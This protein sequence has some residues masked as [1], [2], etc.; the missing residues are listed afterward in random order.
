MISRDKHGC[1]SNEFSLLVM[2]DRVACRCERAGCAISY[3]DKRQAVAIKHD[4]VDLA[5][6]AVKISRNR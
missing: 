3:F 5:A 6:A 2:I 4:Q 1:R